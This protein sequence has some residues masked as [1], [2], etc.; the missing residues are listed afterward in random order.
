[1]FND[2]SI[3]MNIPMYR[4]LPRACVIYMSGV[5][6]MGKLHSMKKKLIDIL[7]YLIALM[8]TFRKSHRH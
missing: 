3:L 6:E 2:I 5:I 4:K 8:S 7:F 1:M